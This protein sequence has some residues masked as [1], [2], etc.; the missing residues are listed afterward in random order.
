MK[1]TFLGATGTVTGSKY[2]IEDGQTTVLVD[3]GLFQGHKELRE[4]N[5]QHLPIDAASLD[6]VVLTHA[7]IDHSG[8]VPLLIKQGFSG[9][10]YCSA[11]TLDLCAVLLPDAGH[12]QE[13]DAA[14]ANRYGYSK[15]HP[16]LP[17]YTE[18]DAR[19]AMHQFHP[20]NF[21]QEYALGESLRFSLSRAGHI[22]GA[23]CVSIS[24]GHTRVVFSGDLGRPNDPIMPAPAQIQETDYL[25]LESTYG[26]RLHDSDDLEVQ[27]A[28]I[29]NRTLERGG[30]LII[31]SFAV[32]RAQTL[33]YV[34]YQLRQR[35]DI[36][37]VPIYLDS[38]MAVNAT[39]IWVDHHR[40][41]RLSLDRC[42]E[43]C[44]VAQY[45]QSPEQSEALDNDP[46]PKIIISASGMATG[47]RV[48]HHLAS[49]LSD[50]RNGVLF[51]G[52][53]AAGTRG[54]RLVNGET[55]IRMFGENYPVAAEINQLHNV[56]AHADYQEILEWLGH[57]RE[58]PMHTYLTHGEPEASAALQE[59]ITGTLNWNVSVPA[60]R[61]SIDL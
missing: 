57:F 10:V 7:H 16:A 27:V 44:A 30:T 52:F 23:A 55:S 61:Q 34:L 47:G 1:L 37:D 38:P 18:Q 58:P 56:S 43:I 53:Q 21:G 22:L 42:G 49:Y 5:W 3:C 46:T 15:H 11:A 60:Y 48:L 6:A 8:Y 50:A 28:G 36:P 26:N 13:E 9:P 41:H 45:V 32:G 12:I 39:R 14:R 2:L 31:P 24:D 40:E 59:K 25:V 33:M 17:L 35:G 4:R 20:V 51:A 54:A 29:V 19:D